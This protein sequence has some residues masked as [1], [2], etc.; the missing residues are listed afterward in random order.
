MGQ[1]DGE[2][3]AEQR[4]TLAE[5]PGLRVRLLSLAPGESVPWHLHNRISDTFVCLRGPMRVH[6]RE[7]DEIRDLQVG[8]MFEVKSPRPHHVHGAGNAPCK[9]IIIQGVGE[10]DYVGLDES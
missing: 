8:E 10:Y 3:Q 7:P 9:F 2:Y 4:E 5:A 1:A 6:L